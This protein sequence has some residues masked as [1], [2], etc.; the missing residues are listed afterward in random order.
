MI[1]DEYDIVLL[2][3]NHGIWLFIK[4]YD[5]TIFEQSGIK[6]LDAALAYAK[7][8]IE[9]EDQKSTTESIKL[10]SGN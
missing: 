4:K 10:D 9:T 5:V 2:Q 3:G 6:T 8:V 1:K 7:A